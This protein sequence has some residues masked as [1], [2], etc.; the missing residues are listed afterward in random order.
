MS[1]ANIASVPTPL[2]ASVP[3]AMPV[4]EAPVARG[5][6]ERMLEALI[7]RSWF[8]AAVTDENG[9]VTWATPAFRALMGGD[10]EPVG[11]SLFTLAQGRTAKLA[12]LLNAVRGIAHRQATA[13]VDLGDAVAPHVMRVTVENLVADPNVRGVLW[14]QNPE[15]TPERID[16]LTHALV[17]IAREVEWVGFGRRRA[18]G[19]PTPIGML[20]GSDRLSDRER[21]VATMLAKGDSVAAIAE[22]LYVSPSTVRN[23]LSS[24]YRK[25]NVR[26]LAALRELLA[27]GAKTGPNLRVVDTDAH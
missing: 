16:R 12:G 8:V 13:E 17:N 6:R 10:G 20:S 7:E 15:V 11:R 4:T 2:A 27:G 22:R 1:V 18:S 23:Y 25:L 14:W 24:M 19:P 3:A 9:T 26:D 21:A 5:G